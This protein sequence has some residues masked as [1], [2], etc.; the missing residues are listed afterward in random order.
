MDP[1][2]RI[3]SETVVASTAA[4]NVAKGGV[5]A[6]DEALVK[7]LSGTGVARAIA[8]EDVLITH[9]DAEVF[10]LRAD[11]TWTQKPLGPTLI[12]ELLSCPGS[13]GLIGPNDV[14]VPNEANDVRLRRS[15]RRSPKELPCRDPTA[16]PERFYSAWGHWQICRIVAIWGELGGTRHSRRLGR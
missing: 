9:F 6:R 13:L 16:P 4:G 14:V 1:P 12:Q 2:A 15:G 5:A 7:L 11:T 10:V 3:V 8:E